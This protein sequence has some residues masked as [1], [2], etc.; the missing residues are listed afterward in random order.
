MSKPRPRMGSRCPICGKVTVLR[1]PSPFG[2]I[3]A[4]CAKLP[5][6]AMFRRPKKQK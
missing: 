3:C 2:M 1:V 6:E 4:K 5:G